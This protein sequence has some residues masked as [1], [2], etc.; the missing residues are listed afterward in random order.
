MIERYSRPEISNVWSDQNKFRIWL[1]IE[2]ACTEAR[3]KMNEVDE[4][5]YEVIKKKAKFDVKRILEIE[6][7]VKHDVIAFLTN[8]NENIGEEGKVLHYGMTSSDVL[9]TCFSIQCRDSAEII[10]KQLK[11]LKEELRAKAL[12][13]K[14]LKCMGR[15]HGVH[16][17][18]ITY[19]LKFALWFD[20]INRNIKRLEVAKK[21]VSVGKISGAVGTYEHLSP[22]VEEYVCK[23]LKL[24]PAN[25][26]TQIIQ[27]DIYAEF[28]SALSLIACTL[29]KIATEIRHLQK[30]EVLEVEEPFMSGQKGSSAMPHKKNPIICERIA[31]MSRLLRG[32]LIVALENITLWHER[33]ISHSSAE[34][35]VFPDSTIALDYMIDKMIFVIKN[36]KINEKNIEKNINLTKGLISSQKLLLKLVQKGLTREEAYK[37]VQKLALEVWNRD[38][39][40][41]KLVLKDKKL[42]Q[43]IS[44]K[45]LDDVFETDSC[46]KNVDYIFNK[47]GI[48]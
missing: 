33:D 16:A 4:K 15:T 38:I 5:T 26:T 9:D 8:L 41:K 37:I 45:D 7:V 12:A 11:I 3:V 46:L 22:K 31:G 17:E 30:T 21:N 28:L 14:Y 43:L 44:E 23:K 10:L 34:R 40:L 25:I 19:G 20:E 1:D 24:K 48:K 6:E 2:L 13:T 27:R 47:V 35:V 42:K 39:H 36:L 18:L 29:E 32:N